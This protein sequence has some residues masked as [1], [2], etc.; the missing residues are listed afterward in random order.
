MSIKFWGL[1]A[2]V[3]VIVLFFA[4]APSWL[5]ESTNRVEGRSDW[6]VS[7]AAK[8]LHETLVIGDMHADSL[9]WNR[10][11][12]DEADYGHVDIPRLRQG[13]VAIQFF[14]TV[15]KS[16]RGL[17]YEENAAQALDNITLL[18]IAQL[19]PP[20][21]WNSLTARA[22]YQAEKLER[23]ATRAPEQLLILRTRADLERL[24]AE[25]AQGKELIGGVLGTEGSHALDGDIDNVDVLFEN[26]FRM[27]SLQHF[28]DN[29]LGGSLHGI[30]KAGLTPFGRQV[31][32]RI[33]EKRIILDVSHSSEAVV[34]DVMALTDQ[35]LVVSHTGFAGLCNTPRN[36]SDALMQRITE[37]GGLI[38]VG[39]WDEAICDSS[40]AGIVKAIRY[41]IDTFGEDHIALGSDFDGAVTTRIDTSQ[42][43]AITEEMLKAGF[44]EPE[45]RKVM[46]ENLVRFL[47]DSLPQS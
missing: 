45:I 31:V 39:Y 20:S 11:L 8:Q 46:G 23:L 22:L 5:E 37:G 16:P 25:R 26:G 34:R 33:V 6:P 14:T 15:T 35:A 36:I 32:E 2:I 18:A 43:S 30:D 13:N 41:G 21:T 28:F 3:I 38:G 44:S 7:A 4:L 27:M 10:D 12:L 19:W 47:R 24:L 9:L 17:N 40:P 1:S 42:L 29:K